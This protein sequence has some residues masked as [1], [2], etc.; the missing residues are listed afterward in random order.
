MPK[1]TADKDSFAQFLARH[2]LPEPR[3]SSGVGPGWIPLL[4]EL[5]TKLKAAGWTGGFAQI[6]EKLGGLRAYP[7]GL[8]PPEQRKIIWDAE[9]RSMTICEQ[10]GQPGA[11][12]TN[13]H[14]LMT[15]C[16]ACAPEGAEPYK[17]DDSDEDESP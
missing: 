13:K 17:Q 15:R 1:R 5:V 12:L 4:D 6:K 7:E 10:C 11:L 8:L 14:W 2:G 16:P 9:A 3:C